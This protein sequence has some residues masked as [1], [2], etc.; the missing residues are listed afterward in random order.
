MKKAWLYFAIALCPVYPCGD[1]MLGSAPRAQPERHRS[2]TDVAVL[3][4]GR[5]ALTANHTSD[6]VS[7]IDLMA[8]TIL[9][10]QPCGRK[11]TAVACSR[12]GHHA[13]VSNLWDGTLT[14]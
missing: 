11:P 2:P 1:A 9:A 14:L 5:L 12:D 3:P 8:G 4:G 10:E 13:A 6:S 7:L